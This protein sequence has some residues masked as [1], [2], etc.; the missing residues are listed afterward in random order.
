MPCTP[1]A[2]GP[3]TWPTRC[4]ASR[5]LELLGWWQDELDRCYAGS[6]THPVFVA[7]KATIDEFQ[8]PRE[9]FA[10]LLD[11]FRQDQSVTRYATHDDVLAYCRN[12][13]NP[14]GRLILY[15]ARRMTTSGRRWP[16]R[17]ARACNWPISVRTWPATGPLIGFI[18]REKRWRA[19]A[20]AVRLLP[21]RLAMRSFAGCWRS[22][23]SEP[24]RI[25]AAASRW[26][27]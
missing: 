10:R 13:A 17:S 6:A 18:C 8:I 2:A 15:L 4:A 21:A 3:T 11:A 9:P 24:R 7:L 12:S 14:V 19:P 26:W 27:G 22:R 25:Y 23:S 5:S 20:G 16:I 1:I